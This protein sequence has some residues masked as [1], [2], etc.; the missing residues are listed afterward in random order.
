MPA[1][2]AFR[3]EVTD[4]LPP[5]EAWP[6]LAQLG[7]RFQSLLARIAMEE[8]PLNAEGIHELPRSLMACAGLGSMTALLFPWEAVCRTRLAGLDQ[9]ASL[10]QLDSDGAV[11]RE[12]WSW[13]GLTSMDV[14]N[15]PSPCRS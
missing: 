5:D 11:P 12:V 10:H 2:E 9:L 3:L 6:H 7:A 13:P 8:L 14:Q 4:G 15:D 1:L